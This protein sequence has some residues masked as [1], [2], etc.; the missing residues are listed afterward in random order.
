MVRI[1]DLPVDMFA[2]SL[3]FFGECLAS[4][5]FSYD[6]IGGCCPKRESSYVITLPL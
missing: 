5:S 6:A 2:G 3:A 4:A 1:V